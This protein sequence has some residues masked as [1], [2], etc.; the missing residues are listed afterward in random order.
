MVCSIVAQHNMAISSYSI[1][2][3]Q[4]GETT[5]TDTVATEVETNTT[6]TISKD[7]KHKRPNHFKLKPQ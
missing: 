1:W 6:R 3:N 5:E 2:L 4:I 7:M